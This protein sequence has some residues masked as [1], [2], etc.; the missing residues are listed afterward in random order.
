MEFLE[1]RLRV[2]YVEIFKMR[3]CYVICLPSFHLCLCLSGYLSVCLSV[4]LSLSLSLPVRVSIS[5]SFF[6]PLFPSLSLCLLICPCLCLCAQLYICN[7]LERAVEEIEGVIIQCMWKVFR[8]DHLVCQSLS[9]N[10]NP[11]SQKLP[12]D[13]LC[14]LALVL[15]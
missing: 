1:D 3:G 13:P 14:G 11:P 9:G 4:F 8:G 10:R 7:H 2:L 15:E 6:L 12:R 5:L